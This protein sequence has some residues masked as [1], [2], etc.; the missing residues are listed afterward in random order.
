MVKHLSIPLDDS[1]Y[2][3]LVAIKGKKRT[4]EEFFQDIADGKIK[5]GE[6]SV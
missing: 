2:D 3:K 5:G 4:W 1:L 6:K